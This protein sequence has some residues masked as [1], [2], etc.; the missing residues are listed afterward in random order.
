M[1]T[2]RGTCN[3]PSEIIKESRSARHE[4]RDRGRRAPRAPLGPVALLAPRSIRRTGRRRRPEERSVGGS[5]RASE[6]SERATDGAPL[7]GA[8]W[9]GKSRPPIYRLTGRLDSSLR[10]KL[11]P[12][13]EL[14]CQIF[15]A[16]N[17]T[18]YSLAPVRQVNRYL[19]DRYQTVRQKLN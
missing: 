15:G 14:D 11:S 9:P 7:R 4:C 19:S 3:E 6:A 12:K 1:P 18:A 17:C 2:H 16:L 8:S 5:E 10:A 13:T